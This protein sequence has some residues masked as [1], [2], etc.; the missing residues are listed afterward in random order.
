MIPYDYGLAFD[1][2]A[3]AGVFASPCVGGCCGCGSVEDALRFDETELG[4]VR[5]VDFHGV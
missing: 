3:A 2:F 1:V 5:N 4:A